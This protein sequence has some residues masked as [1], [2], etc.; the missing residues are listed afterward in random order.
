MT[1]T[2]SNPF[3]V[4]IQAS[5]GWVPLPG[6]V[7]AVSLNTPNAVNPYPSVVPY[8]SSTAPGTY[9]NS[10]TF[11]G[12]ERVF[13]AWSGGVL[14]PDFGPLGSLV[15]WG[16]GHGDYGGNEVYRYDIFTRL[17]S[18]LTNPH[19]Y[20]PGASGASN[21]SFPWDPTWGD[22]NDNQTP[23]PNH[24]YGCQV[25]LT[26]ALAGNTTGGLLIPSLG[27]AGTGAVQIRRGHLFNTDT[28]AWSRFGTGDSPGTTNGTNGTACLDTSR[29]CLWMLAGS[30]FNIGKLDIAT[31]TWTYYT[32]AVSWNSDST[33]LYDPVA[34]LILVL[35]PQIT[36]GVAD[37]GLNS[38]YLIDPASPSTAKLATYT[39]TAPTNGG[40][41]FDRCSITDKFYTYPGNGST[42]LRTLTRPTVG[43][44][45]DGSWTFGTESFTGTGPTAANLVFG[46]F[47]WVA[48][49]KCFLYFGS[50]I[51]GLANGPVFAYRPTGT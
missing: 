30:S 13:S 29:N 48:A 28:N 37:T 2:Y 16:G 4:G 27:A 44:N 49:I 32:S 35:V 36:G 5:A 47:R 34:D 26:G 10:G 25:G 14:C 20:A 19:N 33:A 1:I 45:W 17:H 6:N 38:L 42:T 23:L 18:R 43:G 22:F 21:G 46:K 40:C 41:G 15:Y 24:N 12:Q 51:N 39:G 7:A 9:S 8:P 11:G 3:S 31:A 50:I